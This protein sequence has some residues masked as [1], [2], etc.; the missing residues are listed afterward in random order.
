MHNADAIFYLVLRAINLEGSLNVTRFLRLS[1]F[2]DNP[3]FFSFFSLSKLLLRRR[4]DTSIYICALCEKICDTVV[5][6]PLRDP[7][8]TKRINF[9]RKFC[10]R[11]F[12]TYEDLSFRRSR[13]SDSRIPKRICLRRT[14]GVKSPVKLRT[15][16]YRCLSGFRLYGGEKKKRD[17]ND[18]D[19]CDNATPFRL[20][21][22]SR[23]ISLLFS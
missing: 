7:A 3:F 2:Q 6:R 17:E 21:H 14:R 18:N 9:R 16:R 22:L 13:V 11:S 8:I 23:D 12:R 20:I 5:S 19:N 4:V 15:S 1:V 10:A